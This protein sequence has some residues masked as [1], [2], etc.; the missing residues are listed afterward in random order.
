MIEMPPALIPEHGWIRRYVDL[1]AP[2]SEAPPE[3]HMATA[4]AVLSAAIGWRAYIR[5]GESS[6]PCCLFV[7]LEGGS[8]TA[9]KTTTAKTG[10]GLVRHAMRTMPQGMDRPL[11]VR[12]ISHTSRRGLIE[13]V[14]TADEA[15]AM[16]WEVTPPPGLLL[17][18]DEFGAVLGRP[19][20]VK[21][22]DWLG[23][24]RAT[25]M[26]L[27]GGWHGGIQTGEM[28]FRPSR[29]AV[30][31]L[32]TM[33]RQ[34][35]EQRMSTGLMRDGFLGR[36][37]MIP[38]PGRKRY[39]SE[40]PE[41]TPL[42]SQARDR[43]AAE[44]REVA[45]SKQEIGS[46]FARYTKEAHDFRASWYENRMREMDAAA[47]AGGEV[48]QAMADAMGRLQSTAAKVSAVL[49]VSER[50]S[51]EDLG[52]LRIDW[53]HVEQGIEFAELALREV[54]ALAGQGAGMPTDRYG[55]KVLDYL[56]RRNGEGPVSRKHLI[57]TVRMDGLDSSACWRVV[58]R[59]HEEGKLTIRVVKT[60]GRPR[61]EVSA[62]H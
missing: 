50:E 49:A 9:K 59:L 25:L 54:G 26:E 55:R 16:Q 42:D 44:L 23:Q 17:D 20:D 1:Y 56:A 24:V 52:E 37:V 45:D 4:L 10:S 6:E 58:E 48:E 2:M 33:T 8:A 18:W 19:G 38:H 39:M 11:S 40:P 22:A 12:S 47:D 35:L 7:M 31:V 62:E 57:D 36:F 43:L 32:A 5:W 13:L 34:E 14:G 61:Q 51:G 21:G 28:K 60:A 53:Q 46:V 15:K 3:A 27:Y 41:W 29:C 30:S